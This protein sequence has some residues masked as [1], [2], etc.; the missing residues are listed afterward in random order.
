MKKIVPFLM[1]FLICSSAFAQNIAGEWNGILNVQA[2]QI[3]LVFHISET[4][5]GL[6]AA[7]DSPDQGAL[8]IPV[9]KI[10]FENSELKMEIQSAGI[11]YEAKFENNGFTGT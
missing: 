8:G 3:R 5:T 4:E 6:K 1:L 11:V 9:D 7:M 2:M 10:S